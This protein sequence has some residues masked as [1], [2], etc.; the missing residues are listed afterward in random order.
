M[1]ILRSSL[2][3]VL[4]HRPSRHQWLRSVD[5]KCCTGNDS[6]FLFP[7][8]QFCFLWGNNLQ[9]SLIPS[10]REAFVFPLGRTGAE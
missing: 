4:A 9:L 6:V 8:R 1:L 3:S 2:W 10:V 5:M 7:F